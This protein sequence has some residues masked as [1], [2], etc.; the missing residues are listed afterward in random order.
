MTGWLCASV[1]AKSP[2]IAP[3]KQ[4]GNGRCFRLPGRASFR[5]PYR[6]EQ[7]ETV[8][9]A[10]HLL[11]LWW[12]NSTRIVYVNDTPDRFGFAYGTLTGHVEKGE[13]LFEVR[14]REDGS[15]WY[16]LE[17]FSRP[18][19]WYVQLGKPIARWSQARFRQQSSQQMINFVNLPL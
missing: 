2:G 4:S 6:S 9:V 3:N 5:M 15:V 8:I 10:F 17:A 14:R 13:E 11:G 12:L 16:H 19:P 18:G 1:K 7:G